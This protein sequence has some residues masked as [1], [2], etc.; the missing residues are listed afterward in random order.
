VT[1]DGTLLR[2]ED[3]GIGIPQPVLTSDGMGLRIMADRAKLI[4]A[5]LDIQS[6]PKCGTVMSCWLPDAVIKQDQRYA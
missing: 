6:K 5:K 1:E 4:G 3:N 2:V